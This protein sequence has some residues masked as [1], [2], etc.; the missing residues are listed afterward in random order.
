MVSVQNLISFGPLWSNFG[1][2]VATKW[3]QMVVSDHYLKKYLLN[4]TQT[5]CVHLFGKCSEFIRLWATLAKLWPSS[6]QITS[7]G[8]FRPLS[9]KLFTQSNSNLMCTLTWWVSRIDSLLDH[10]G[11]IS[12]LLCGH[13]FTENGVF[14]L[15][16]EKVFLQSNSNLVCTLIGWVF[17]I[18][19]L[20]SHV[21]QILAL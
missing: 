6:G 13:I 2:L 9:E 20:L 3:L 7:D 14:L 17:R 10:V 11:Q 18:D 21:G 8:G 19:S 5:R 1:P 15:S 12:A 16:S 4:R